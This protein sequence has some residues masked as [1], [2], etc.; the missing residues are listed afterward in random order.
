MVWLY[1]SPILVERKGV[2]YS[3]KLF[4]P[5][6]AV[7]REGGGG[8]HPM[9][10]PLTYTMLVATSLH[11]TKTEVTPAKNYKILWYCS[12]SE[13]LRGKFKSHGPE[14]SC[15]TKKLELTVLFVTWNRPWLIL[16]FSLLTLTLT[17]SNYYMSPLSLS[18]CFSHWRFAPFHVFFT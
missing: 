16:S 8:Q 13:G 4:L 3:Y 11:N 6:F 17:S 9:D 1:R 14:K 15:F 5:A 2:F 7:L 18:A 12:K 10:Y